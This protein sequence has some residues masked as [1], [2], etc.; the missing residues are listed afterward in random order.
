MSSTS[1]KPSTD[2][3]PSVPAPEPKPLPKTAAEIEH[4]RVLKLVESV[5]AD[6]KVFV[7]IPWEPNEQRVVRTQLDEAF[8]KYFEVE[9]VCKTEFKAARLP[10]NS[11][12]FVC[13]RVTSRGKR[14]D[15]TFGPIDRVHVGGPVHLGQYT[16]ASSDGYTWNTDLGG[17]VDAV[18]KVCLH[19]N[20]IVWLA[21]LSGDLEMD[22]KV[23]K[24]HFT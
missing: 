22:N 18:T 23:I 13:H 12:L 15:G 17:I 6:A 21:G 8:N 11:Y 10:P 1:S 19:N 5:P 2:T 4:E 14:D 9:P 3:K 16:N 24:L 7:L 20:G